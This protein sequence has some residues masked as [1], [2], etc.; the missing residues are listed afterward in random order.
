MTRVNDT[1]LTPTQFLDQLTERLSPSAGQ[2]ALMLFKLHGMRRM[3]SLFGARTTERETLRL[4]E[5]MQQALRPDDRIYRLGAFEYAILVTNIM[6][7]GHAILAANKIAGI[8]SHPVVIQE[9]SRTLTFSIGL[10][11]S[12]EHSTDPEQ[13]CKYAERASAAARITQKPYQLFDAEGLQ[14]VV[15]NWDIEGDLERALVNNE[16]HLHYQPKYDTASGQISGAEALLRWEHPTQGMVPPD[17]FIPV[18]ERSG[19][20][21]QLTWWV[22]NTALRE[23]REWGGPANPLSVA[24]NLSA[25]DLTDSSFSKSISQAL[26]IWDTDP[27][28]LTL[29]IT[30]G[31]LMQDIAFSASVL[32]KIRDLG[33]GVSIDD[34]GTGYSSLAYFKQL[35]ADELKIDRSFILNILNDELDQHVVKTIIQMAKRMALTIVAEG[36][37]T[38]PVQQTLIE[39]GCDTIQGYHIAR[40]MP[41]QAFITW[42]ADREQPGQASS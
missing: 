6:N 38:E 19:I 30:E 14:S 41:Q 18:A 34:F 4:A 3:A 31:A 7:R 20:M 33:I 35:P 9:K 24:I 42:L 12:P 25:L 1:I 15:D 13:L 21:P 27:K 17:R 5:Q 8:L 22:L 39:F 10:A 11:L 28:L 37:E 36:V 2:N 16:L 32:R 40:P 26:G 29:E 23:R